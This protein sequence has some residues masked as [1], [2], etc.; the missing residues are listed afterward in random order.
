MMGTIVSLGPWVG[1]MAAP[2]IRHNSVTL[3]WAQ[4]HKGVA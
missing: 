4:E 1:H 2:K 3:G